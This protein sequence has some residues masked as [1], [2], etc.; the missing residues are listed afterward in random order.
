MVATIRK[1]GDEATRRSVEQAEEAQASRRLSWWWTLE[2]TH[3]CLEGTL[4]ADRGAVF[5]EVLDRLARDLPEPPEKEDGSPASPWWSDNDATL[6]QRRADALVLLA[7]GHCGGSPETDVTT[8][9][10]HA[11]LQSLAADDGNCS[12][13]RG[14][15]L[16]PETTRRLSCD[17]RLRVVLYGEDGNALEIGHTSRVVPTW[18]RSHVFHR[19][20]NTCTFPGCEMTR[21]IS[22]HHI[23]HWIRE[24]PTDLDN[25]NTVCSFHQTLSLHTASFSDE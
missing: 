13:A 16:H 17:A 24:G 25:L 5:T 10:L 9:V 19:D 20:G 8:L 22:P 23:Q 21:F 2:G 18:L 6:Q 3:L 7:S 14:P 15:V 4:T 12:F 11:P 1:R